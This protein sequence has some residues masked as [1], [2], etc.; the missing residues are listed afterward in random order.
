MIYTQNG[1]GLVRL[2]AIGIVYLIQELEQQ[3]LA[4]SQI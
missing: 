4:Q 1:M 3:K 2:I